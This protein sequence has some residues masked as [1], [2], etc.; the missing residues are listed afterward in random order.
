MFDDVTCED[1]FLVSDG[2]LGSEVALPVVTCSFPRP[3]SG[4]AVAVL[5]GEAVP[6]PELLDFE[7]LLELEDDVDVDSVLVSLDPEMA[8]VAKPTLVRM[9]TA[10]K[11]VDLPIRL[12]SLSKTA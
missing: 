10:C 12:W 8:L 9:I 2:A 3:M 7:V 5:S 6:D 1:D 4:S 11:T